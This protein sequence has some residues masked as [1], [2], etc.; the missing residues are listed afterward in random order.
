MV[1]PQSAQGNML[2]LTWIS[3]ILVRK[4]VRDT[5]GTKVSE[6]AIGSVIS[7]VAQICPL[8]F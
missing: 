8:P 1:I 7:T 4:V 3:F 2:A 5:A 6:S